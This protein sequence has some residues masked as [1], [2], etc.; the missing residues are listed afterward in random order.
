[1]AFTKDEAI[2]VVVSRES[3]GSRAPWPRPRTR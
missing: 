1:M 2:T 3:P